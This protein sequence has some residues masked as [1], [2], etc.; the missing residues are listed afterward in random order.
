MS[1]RAAKKSTTRILGHSP[2]GHIHRRSP[3]PLLGLEVRGEA[4]TT[5]DSEESPRAQHANKDLNPSI[6]KIREVGNDW[7]HRVGYFGVGCPIRHLWTMRIPTF[8]QY[9]GRN[10]HC[11]F[12]CGGGNPKR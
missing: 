6:D 7:T 3:N 1:N 9:L 12:P 10:H 5:A 4:A 8:E 2:A 11:I